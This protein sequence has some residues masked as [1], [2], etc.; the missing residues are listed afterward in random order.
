MM[1]TKPLLL[2]NAH[3]APVIYFDGAPVWG[4][5]NGV[6]ELGLACRVINPTADGSAVHADAS[7]VA[8]LRCS[9]TAAANLRDALNGALAMFE[10]ASTTKN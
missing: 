5:M 3:T 2:K 1:T 6:V 7:C 10:S 4:T 8:Q 9:A